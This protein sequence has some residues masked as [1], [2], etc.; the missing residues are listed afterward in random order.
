MEIK[1]CYNIAKYR[2][3]NGITQAE[4]AEYL[5]VSPQAVS[6]WEQEISIPDIYLIPK[7]AYFFNISIDT[8]FGTSNF[9]TTELL[10]SKYS[11]VC[12]DKN[13]K[14]A[15]EAIDSLLDMN[16]E[17]LKALS[18]L[19][20]L[21]HQRA[22][23]FLQKSIKAC[24]KLKQK[25]KNIDAYWEKM[26]SI[27][28]M[29]EKSMLGNYDFVNEYM[30]KFEEN[31]TGENFNYLLLAITLSV[32]EQYKKALWKGKEYIDSFTYQE[33]LKIYPNLME[34]AYSLED[35]DYVRKCFDII[36]KDTENKDQIFNAWWLLWK[37]HK[38]AGK[39]KEA[40]DC[41]RELLNLLPNQNYNEYLYEEIERHLL[42]EGNKPE[43]IW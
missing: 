27:Q 7:I 32:D 17:D 14:E 37:S 2:K 39:E 6:K 15:K 30:Q 40:E 25:A 35:F 18:L 16:S 23:E 12:N 31:K 21:E 29:R 1:I 4:L 9:D 8:L 43:I 24:E 11:A 41:K 42:G 36:T 33:Q 20:R 34:I 38:S 13:Y 19:C 26:A 28:L 22:L 10:V 5:G 3:E